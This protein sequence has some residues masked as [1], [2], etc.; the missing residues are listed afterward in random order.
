MFGL[1][2]ESPPTV[3]GDRKHGSNME[4]TPCY[5]PI[6]LSSYV[7]FSRHALPSHPSTA[8]GDLKKSTCKN[9]RAFSASSYHNKNTRFI[10]Y[11]GGY[12]DSPRALKGSVPQFFF[13]PGACL[14]YFRGV[15]IVYRQN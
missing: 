15:Y 4:P 7:S 11:R 1:L 12:D 2:S 9:P 13:G 3:S 8:T 5:H 6:R 14:F 10:E